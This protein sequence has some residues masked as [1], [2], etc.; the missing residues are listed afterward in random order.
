MKEIERKFLVND[1]TF[2]TQA[3]CTQEISQGY[4]STHP[5]RTV[6]VRIANEQGFITVKTR[7]HGASRNEWEYEIPLA[8]A[9]EMLREAANGV[10]EKTRYII[11]A[12]NGLKWEVDV[13]HGALDGLIIAEIELPSEDTPFQ[14][15]SFVGKEVTGDKRYYNSSLLEA[16]E[17]D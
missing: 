14:L 5:D 7:N 16:V 12:E 2:I 1:H 13:F 15:P 9:R 3:S 10:L 8:D 11:P 17:L 4:L 6:R